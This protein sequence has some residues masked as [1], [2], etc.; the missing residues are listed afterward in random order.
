[1]QFKP[2]KT[3]TF[4]ALQVLSGEVHERLGPLGLQ[5]GMEDGALKIHVKLERGQGEEGEG[6][7]LIEEGDSGVVGNAREQ[8][9]NTT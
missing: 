5:S 9:N 3:S 7:R 4:A 2:W 6:W 1:M 8:T